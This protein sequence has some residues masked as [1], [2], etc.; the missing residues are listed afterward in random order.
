LEPLFLYDKMK[1]RGYDPLY[2][3]YLKGGGP[4]GALPDQHDIK[5]YNEL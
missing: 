5:G 4:N 1:K 2:F 3:T